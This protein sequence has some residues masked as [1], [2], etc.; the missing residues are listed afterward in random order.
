MSAFSISPVRPNELPVIAQLFQAYAE[1]LGIDLSFQDFAAEL[2]ALPGKYASPRGLLLLARGRQG[3]PIGCVG[4][5]PLEPKGCCEMKR[6]YVAPYAR[7]MGLGQALIDAALGQAKRLGYREMRLDTLG[8]MDV[9]LT[10]YE[11][12]GFTRIAPYYDTPLA[13]TVF[14]SR[15]L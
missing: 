4:L 2:Q 12:N 9:A 10:L 1:G 15:A 14:L 8:S 11:K 13:D 3:E 5:R 6:L 7:K